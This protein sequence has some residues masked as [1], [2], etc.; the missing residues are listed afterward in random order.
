MAATNH[1]EPSGPD[2]QDLLPTPKDRAG[3]RG[4]FRVQID[5]DGTIVGDSGWRENTVTNLGFNLYL[6]SVLGGISGSSLVAWA[7]LGT[8]GAPVT[9]DYTLSGELTKR[10]AVTGATSS[11]SKTLRF[12]GTFQSTA[13]F[14]TASVNISNIGLFAASTAGTMFAGNVFT[15]SN[16]GQNQNVN[17]TYDLIFS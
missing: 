4:M 14:A 2:S 3:V 6:V 13:S 12:T 15:S 10:A 7:G 11:T 17:V 5:E 16:C 1:V 8:G 9:G